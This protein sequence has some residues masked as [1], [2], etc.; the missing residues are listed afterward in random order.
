[1]MGASVGLHAASCVNCRLYQI[2]SV[3]R[4]RHHQMLIGALICGLFSALYVAAQNIVQGHRFNILEDIDCYPALF[5]S[6][7]TYFI[8]SMWPLLI[9]LASPLPAR[10][11]P[12]TCALHLPPN[13]APRPHPRALPPPLRARPNRPPPLAAFTIA[14]PPTPCVFFADTHFDFERVEGGFCTSLCGLI[15]FA[16][17]GFAVEARRHYAMFFG[18]VATAFWRCAARLGIHRPALGF[19]AAASPKGSFG[20]ASS[21]GL[22]DPSA[23]ATGGLSLKA[24]LPTTR[25]PISNPIPI[26]LP[27]YAS[28]HF[29]DLKRAGSSVSASSAGASSRLVERFE[30]EPE[31]PAATTS[32]SLFPSTFTETQT[33]THETHE[34][35]LPL[36]VAW[37]D[38]AYPASP[39]S[40]AYL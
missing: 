32:F 31:T 8:S 29:T 11:L 23:K 33:Q 1:M 15:F 36:H 37:H 16:F 10:L 21:K 9:G 20:F 27:T 19:L 3:A 26:A 5:N 24:S 4:R 13:R 39:A 30:G 7:P 25:K 28:S 12:P 34:Y 40:S 17:F 38:A 18:V 2:A 6:L 35:V 22:G 14:S